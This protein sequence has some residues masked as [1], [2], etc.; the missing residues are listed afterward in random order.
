MQTQAD[1]DNHANQLN[2][3]H[4]EYWHSRED[5]TVSSVTSD[6]NNDN[7]Y[8]YDYNY[9]S[10]IPCAGYDP[11]IFTTFAPLSELKQQNNL[12]KQQNSAT[13]EK[14]SRLKLEIEKLQRTNENLQRTNAELE[15]EYVKSEA[16]A[17]DSE[18]LAKKIKC[19]WGNGVK[20]KKFQDLL[21]EII[22]LCHRPSNGPFEDIEINIRYTRD[23]PPEVVVT[24]PRKFIVHSNFGSEGR[25]WLI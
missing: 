4:K 24:H 20:S 23:R 7:Y 11:A 21:M 9:D 18:T 2:P 19:D 5:N 1:L 10:D 15:R 12:L 16:E 13:I 14:N 17:K 6:T 25:P 8:D 22:H 3:D